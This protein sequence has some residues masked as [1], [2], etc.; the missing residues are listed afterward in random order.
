MIV[1]SDKRQKKAREA[2]ADDLRNKRMRNE[3]LKR[4]N[5]GSEPDLVMINRE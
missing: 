2:G 3:P 1:R 4:E 5:E